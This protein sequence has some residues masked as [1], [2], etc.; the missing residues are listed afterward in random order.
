[1]SITSVDVV[2]DQTARLNLTAEEGDV[3]I[4]T[5]VNETFV[6]STNDPTVDSNWKKVQLDVV[7]AIDGQTITPGQVGTSS[8]RSKIFANEIDANSVNG[9]PQAFRGF[10]SSNQSISVGSRAKIAFDSIEYDEPGSGNF[11]TSSHVWNCPEDGLYM[12]NVQAF[13]TSGAN[14]D[15]REVLIA[16][17]TN[18]T[19]SG[20]GAFS[21]RVNSFTS[22]KLT[23]TSIARYSQG[24]TIAFYASNQNNNDELS[25]GN[26]NFDTFAEVAFLGQ[27]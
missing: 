19:P 21:R 4:Q 1:L 22:D 2:A 11:D 3:A 18:V 9:G 5:D 8:N 15:Q 13:F 14:G 6:L 17:N 10:L 12:A 27:L 25:S 20:Q 23:A 16:T 24:D 7:G 26:A